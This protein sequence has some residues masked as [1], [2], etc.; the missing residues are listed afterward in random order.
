MLLHEEFVRCPVCNEA[1]FRKNTFVQ[2]N[3]D[4]YGNTS[5]ERKLVMHKTIV[6][7]VCRKCGEVMGTEEIRED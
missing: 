7:Y 4:A 3:K 1:N 5:K 6:E 2:L